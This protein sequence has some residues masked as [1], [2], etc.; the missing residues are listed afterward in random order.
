MTTNKGFLPET[1]RG[2]FKHPLREVSRLQNRIDRLFDDLFGGFGSEGEWGAYS[3][4]PACDYDESEKEFRFNMDL[5]GV[6]KE[7]VKIELHDNQLTVRGERKEEKRAEGARGAMERYY[8]AFERS[9]TLPGTVDPDRVSADY[10][11]GVLTIVVPK[12]AAS[13]PKLIKIGE[14]PKLPKSKDERAA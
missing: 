10:K 3:S 7:D 2:G 9:F 8:G 11:D 5:P 4:L 14:V 13:Q 12:S 6:P 1:Y